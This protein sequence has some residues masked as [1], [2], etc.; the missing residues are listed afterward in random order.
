MKSSARGAPSLLGKTAALCSVGASALLLVVSTEANAATTYPTQPIKLVVPYAPGGANDS[1]AR[2]VGEKL[3]VALEQP[4]VIENRPGAGGLVGTTAVSK[5]A[6]DGYTLLIINTLPH[7]ASGSLYKKPAF[8]PVKDFTAIGLIATTP[9]VLVVKEGNKDTSLKGLLQH[10]KAAPKKV[11]YASGG[12][13]GATHLTAELLVH[14]QDLDVVHVPYRGGGPALT[15]LIGGQ[16]DFTF[17]NIIAVIPFTNGGKLKALAVSSAQPSKA[18]P[19]VPTVASVIGSEF[20]VQGRFAIVGPAGV[21]AP[22]VDKLNKEI[23]KVVN[24]KEIVEFFTKQGVEPKT[25]TPQELTDILKKESVVWS[26]L[27]KKTGISLD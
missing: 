4:V 16:V 18:L 6:P 11:N 21:P 2:I 14:A 27:I 23:G 3:T 7:T 5:A 10:V 19:G 9:Y 20:D 15:D 24:S 26:G 13:G 8:D 1:F 17:E 25:A 22:I 12:V